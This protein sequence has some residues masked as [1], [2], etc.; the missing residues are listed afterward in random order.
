MNDTLLIP[1]GVNGSNG[2]YLLQPPTPRQILEVSLG[3]RLSKEFLTKLQDR[4]DRS[5]E[6]YGVPFGVEPEK[7]SQTGWA[8]L[9]PRDTHPEIIQALRP[10][11][12]LRKEQTGSLYREFLGGEG[13]LPGDTANRWLARAPRSKGPG[14]C[15]CEKVPYYLLIV[16]TPEQI[17]FRFQYELSVNYAV[18]RIHFETLENYRN[19]ANNV[20]RADTRVNDRPR[21][22][23]FG[24]R[25]NGDAATRLS[26]DKL[27]APL[28]V[29]VEHP[30][31][32]IETCLADSATKEMLKLQLFHSGPAPA[33]LFTASH[34]MGFALD[35]PR[36]LRHQGALLCQDWSGPLIHRG[37]IE[38][39]LYFSADDLEDDMD[40]NSMIVMHFACYGAGTPQFDNFS[41]PGQPLRQLASADFLS[42]LPMRALGLAKGAQAV[43]GHIERAWSYAF[44]WPGTQ[45]ELSTFESTLRALMH[46]N[47]RLGHAMA[48]FSERF[49]GLSVALNAQLEDVN[50]GANIDEILLSQLWAA[51]NDARNYLVLGDPAARLGST[52]AV[53]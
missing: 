35:D 43:V 36:Q 33:F 26:A 17:P 53:D 18:G 10:L 38:P 52:T 4:H 42:A 41:R 7:L 2:E 20:V 1:N 15:T 5:V 21:A 51:S 22:L 31:W 8:V 45:A 11:L 50:L 28:A 30:S 37:S 23:F 47:Y 48:F 39:E 9:F 49:A 32:Q 16:G 13:Y 6:H 14:V 34:G 27:V 3:N 46:G 40:L 29:H 12:E 19:F 44:D 24:P 25:N